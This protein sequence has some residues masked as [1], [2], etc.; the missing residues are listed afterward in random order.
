MGLI[1]NYTI[2]ANM[3]GEV[4][5]EAPMQY[6]TENFENFFKLKFLVLA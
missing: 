4:V 3:N 6:H 5:L 1:F 2:L